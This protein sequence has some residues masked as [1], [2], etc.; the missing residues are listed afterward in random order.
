MSGFVQTSIRRR[1]MIAQQIPREK[2]VNLPRHGGF[3]R[4][5]ELFHV[6]RGHLRK[7]NNPAAVASRE[8]SRF[9]TVRNGW[10]T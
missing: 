9:E 3:T 8:T 10:I 5:K 2:N 1:E 4:N 6:I 7:K